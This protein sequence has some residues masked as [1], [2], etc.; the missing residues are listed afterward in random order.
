MIVGS[1]LYYVTLSSLA[2]LFLIWLAYSLFKI[3]LLGSLS[4][5]LAFAALHQFLLADLHWLPVRHRLNFKIA[6]IAFKV[7]QSNSHPILPPLP[8]CI[9]P[10]DHCEFLLPCQWNQYVF[11]HE[12]L[13]W[14]SLSLSHSLPQTFGISYHVI[15]HPYLLFLLSGRDSSNTYFLSAFPGIS[16]SSNDITLCDVIASTNVN[17]ITCNLPTQLTRSSWAPTISLDSHQ[18]I[19]LHTGTHVKVVTYSLTCFKYAPKWMVSCVIFPKF[20]E[21]LKEQ[22]HPPFFLGLR[23]FAFVSRE[24]RALD[25]GFAINFWMGNLVWPKINSWI[26]LCKWRGVCGNEEVWLC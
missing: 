16:F 9:S 3:H 13:Q 12:K 20:S 26:C 10:H 22:M 23:R 8:R 7:L 25:L 21:G 15:F 17:H 6:T 24:L 5:N 14:Q 19:R 1:R 11:L 18:N 4:K 2:H